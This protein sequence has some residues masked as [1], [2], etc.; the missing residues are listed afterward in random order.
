MKTLIV[1]LITVLFFGT[2]DC[3]EQETQTINATYDGYEAS[4]YYFVNEQGD[5]FE[6]QSVDADVLKKYDLKNGSMEGV[7]F[8]VTYTT[9]T[10]VDEFDDEYDAYHIVSLRKI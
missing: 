8:E 2:T 7:N 5:T 4:T 1:S 6:F 10:E 3:I 9:V